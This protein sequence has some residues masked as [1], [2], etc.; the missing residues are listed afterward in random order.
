MSERPRRIDM[1]RWSTG[2][3][4]IQE[5]VD[6]VESMGAHELLTEAVILLGRARDTVADYVDATSTREP[7][8]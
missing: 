3:R 1:R 5:A 4:A 7:N 2:E 8:A 6:V